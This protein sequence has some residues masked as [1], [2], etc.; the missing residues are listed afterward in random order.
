LEDIALA[1]TLG[2]DKRPARPYPKLG[3][4]GYMTLGETKKAHG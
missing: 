1:P 4:V 3:S 2:L